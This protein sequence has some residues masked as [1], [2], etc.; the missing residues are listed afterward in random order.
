VS[1]DELPRYGYQSFLT[2]REIYLL[3]LE[4]VEQFAQSQFG[5]G[6]ADLDTEQLEE[7]VRALA[8][9]EIGSTSAGQEQEVDEEGGGDEEQGFS[10][11]SFQDFFQTVRQH[12]IE[13]MFADPAYG[14]NRNMVGWRLIG[15][16]GAQRAYTPRNIKTPGIG[17]RLAPQSL[18]EL[19]PFNPGVRL[20]VPGEENV[21][22]PVSGSDPWAGQTGFDREEGH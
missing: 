16:P 7:V 20:P 14:G 10:P 3:G 17:R 1:N 5:Q 4:Q 15:Y 2:P 13:G 22:L 12:V 9:G 21:V 8:A 18:A 6:M 11:P 19:P